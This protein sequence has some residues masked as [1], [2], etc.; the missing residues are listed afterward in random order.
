M[1]ALFSRFQNL[2]RRITAGL[3]ARARRF[4][5]LDLTLDTWQAYSQ[6]EMTMLAAALAYYLL[7][8]LFP[9]LL[10]LIAIATPFLSS[11]Q[12]IRETIRFASSYAPTGAAELRRVLEQVINARGPVTLVAAL[13]LLW[14]S[15]GV[16]DL[17]QKGLNRAWHVSQPRPLWRQRLVSI[18]TVVA[19]GL[20]FGL[21]FFTSAFVRSGFRFRVEI[22]GASIE[23]LGLLL[24]LPLNFLLFS[25]IYK[26]FPY[27]HLTYD[28]VWGGALLASILWELAKIVFVVYLLN[29]ARLNLVYGSVGAVIALLLWGYITATI[30]L[31]CAEMSAVHSTKVLARQAGGNT[32]AALG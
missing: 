7:L 8:A 6:H 26:F 32:V 12:V 11:E 1:I 9:L 27:R 10:L 29:F 20:L 19:V 15:S 28:Q 31:F 14:S 21:S 25:T 13:G 22:G 3:D 5:T 18:V 4:A 24:T 17:V 23:L 30:L 16:F 2:Y